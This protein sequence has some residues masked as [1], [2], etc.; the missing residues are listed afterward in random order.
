MNLLLVCL[1]V[2]EL[3]NI[4]ID[5][6]FIHCHFLLSNQYLA[7]FNTHIKINC[8][9]K[10]FFNINQF[11]K[12]VP[13]LSSIEENVQIGESRKR[14]YENSFDVENFLE[15]FDGDGSEMNREL[16]NSSLN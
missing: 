4:I 6:Q 15:E 9:I 7:I 16:I 3:K 14:P 5:K 10:H 1:Y 2:L 12:D 8:I 13:E 11:F